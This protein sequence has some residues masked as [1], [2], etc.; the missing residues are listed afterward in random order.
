MNYKRKVFCAFVGCAIGFQLLFSSGEKM[1][2]DRDD[3]Q[4]PLEVVRIGSDFISGYMERNMS[5]MPPYCDF[6]VAVLNRILQKYWESDDLSRWK[7]KWGAITSIEPSTMKHGGFTLK[8][9]ITMELVG[10]GTC[11]AIRSITIVKEKDRWQ[12]WSF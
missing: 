8:Y 7:I 4:I 12:I 3:I 2:W 11:A 1:D 6:D 10:G 5:A 9:K